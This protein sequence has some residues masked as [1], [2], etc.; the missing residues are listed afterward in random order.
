MAQRIDECCCNFKIGLCFNIFLLRLIRHAHVSQGPPLDSPVPYLGG[1]YPLELIDTLERMRDLEPATIV[2]GHGNVLRGTAYL[3]LVIDFLRAVVTAVDQ[4]IHRIGNG[5]QKLADVKEGIRARFPVAQWRKRF[6]G[7]D[8]EAADFF[9]GFAFD[10]VVTAA[11]A[12]L[13]PR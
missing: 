10:G 6:A 8:K 13:W 11:Y 7:T 9:D 4:E 12:A 1:G 5:S 3:A 2:P